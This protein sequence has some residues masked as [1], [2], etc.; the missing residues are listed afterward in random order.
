[1]SPNN[2][3]GSLFARVTGEWKVIHWAAA[4]IVGVLWIVAAYE[5]ITYLLDS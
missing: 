3:S 2:E 4:I 5:M 1:M